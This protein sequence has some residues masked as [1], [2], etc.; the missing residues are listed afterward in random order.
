VTV[1]AGKQ[2]WSDAGNAMRRLDLATNRLSGGWFAG[3]ALTCV[4]VILP[5]ILGILL[6]INLLEL[7]DRFARMQKA[8]DALLQIGGAHQS[9]VEAESAN[10]AYVLTGDGLFMV[11]FHDGQK[12]ARLYLRRLRGLNADPSQSRNLDRLT[13][14]MEAR[15]SALEWYAGLDPAAA[16]IWATSKAAPAV[17]FRSRQ[18]GLVSDL[19]T[20]LKAF[21]AA[22]REQVLS[23][24]LETERASRQLSYLVLILAGSAPLCGG[25]G[26]YLLLRERY[27]NRGRELQMN[28]MHAQRLGLMGETSFVLA[29]EINQPLTAATNYLAA[30]RRYLERPAAQDTEKLLDIVERAAHQIVRAGK[31]IG[32][33]RHFVE[34]SDAGRVAESPS[35]LIEEALALIG[36]I[37][38]SV[39]FRTHVAP[40]L[41]NIS[42]DRIQIQQVLVNLMRNALEA[43]QGRDHRTLDMTVAA[44]TS[45]GVQF[46]LQDNGPGLSKEVADRLFQ[47][48]VST[49]EDGMGVGLSICRRIIEAHAGRIWAEP[50]PSGGTVFCFVLPALQVPAGDRQ[51]LAA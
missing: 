35:V 13:G 47:P 24:E 20:R 25:V 48:F 23:G 39:A 6:S 38:D 7:Q 43:M 45:G 3:V 42:I 9:M 19:M 22:Q 46:C 2:Q 18:L 16:R 1:S 26:I 15:L 28:L 12:E 29:H 4:A 34:K 41:P 5:I 40:G 31:V 33:L 44:D 37:G 50:N 36:T 14:L 49:K 51:V 10:R 30:L 11:R 32:H 21:R 27:R 8:N 17:A